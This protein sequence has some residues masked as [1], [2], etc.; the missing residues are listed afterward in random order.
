[1]TDLTVALGARSYAIHIAAGV[2]A[3][4]QDLI[5]PHLRGRQVFVIADETVMALHGPTLR[6]GLGTLTQHWLPVPPG[7]SS[8]SLAQFRALTESVLALAPERGDLIIAFGGGVIGD[9]AGY[10]AAS[11]LRG[12]DFVQIP[13]SLLAQVDSSV[14]GKTGINSCL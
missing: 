10:V 7:E 14:G 2:L 1:M 4:A 8:K 5:A 13:T 3:Q 6:A 12:L 11:L 9:L